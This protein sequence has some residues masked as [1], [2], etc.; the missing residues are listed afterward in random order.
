MSRPAGYPP[1]MEKSSKLMV[2]DLDGTLVDTAADLIASLDV[3]LDKRGHPHSEP[4]TARS[5]IGHGARQ[6]I[7]NA[8]EHH[9]IAFDE[10]AIEAMYRD[11]LDHYQANMSRFSRPFPALNEA[12]DALADT[13]WIFAVCSNKQERLCRQLLEELDMSRRFATIS[14]GDTFGVSKP[15]PNHL[16]GTIAA[17][18]GERQ[19]AIMVG[20]A[21]TDV[22]AAKAAS[23]PVI[24][25]TFGYT[26]VPMVELGPDL[27]LDSFADLT[28]A[29]ADGLLHEIV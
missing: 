13:G 14:G 4:V 25:V 11:F 18:S 12:L 3:T 1:G 9:S 15:D 23:V 22:D 27:L 5:W 29:V 17:A 28:P 26:P 24:G 19:R 8:L 7:R 20:D 10:P 6:M 16:L 21:S 2:F